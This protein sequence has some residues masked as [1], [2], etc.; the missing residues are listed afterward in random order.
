MKMAGLIF[1]MPRAGVIDVGEA[2]E[3]KFSIAREAGLGGSAVDFFVHFV[4]RVGA[5]GI[6]E[7]TTAGDLLKRCVDESLE[8]SV[9][10]ALVEITNLP[11]FFLDVAVLHFRL[12][13]AERFR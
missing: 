2:I 8:L 3:G 9:R 11:Q 10:K 12:I 6:D 13:C 5:H 7:P 4:A 1:F